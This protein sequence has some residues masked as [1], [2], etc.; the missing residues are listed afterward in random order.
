M[1]TLRGLL[2]LSLLTS[3]CVDDPTLGSGDQDVVATATTARPEVGRVQR[4]SGTACMGTLV[5]PQIVATNAGCAIAHDATSDTPRAGARFEFRDAA[6]VTRTIN[7]DRA[8][9][10][11]RFSF[12]HLVTAI[13]ASQATPA[14]FSTLKPLEDGAMTAFAFDPSGIF[15]KQLFEYA[16]PAEV[17]WDNVDLGGP[18]F[19]G[20]PVGGDLA[21]ISDRHAWDSGIWGSSS[22]DVFRTE[23]AFDYWRQFEDK[24][25][26]WHGQDEVGFDRYGTDYANTSG[27]NAGSCRALC[28][29]DPQCK[30][31]TLGPTGICWRKKGRTQL[32]PSPGA[33]SG[34]P[35]SSLTGVDVAGTVISTLIAIPP[36]LC[37]AA[38]AADSRCRVWTWIATD[39]WFPT[40]TTCRLKSTR[41]AMTTSALF[42]SGFVD[43]DFEGVDRPGRDYAAAPATLPKDCAK[44]CVEDERC[45]AFTWDGISGLCWL[46]SDVPFAA[47]S[48]TTSSGVRRGVET[49]V[50]RPG[51]D[52]RS[53]VLGT[54]ESPFVDTN[55]INRCQAAC[56]RDTACKAWVVHERNNAETRC[57]LKS[58]VGQ[59]FAKQGTVSGLK[60][61]EFQ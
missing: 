54:D 23:L 12:A 18:H 35:R 13:P 16:F 5:A 10:W 17:R 26:A 40:N 44:R 52:L 53:F 58:A 2:L 49:D 37:E 8:I 41:G 48:S 28:E 31:F 57:Q 56:A 61:L 15:G 39:Q 59:R 55:R 20:A 11:Q 38:C 14:A 46:K 47:A 27:Q 33:V 42:T 36:D 9:A 60:G 7:I 34:L 43:R 1:R 30:A 51:G 24:L 3:A 6:G 32:R 50:D 45:A 19:H 25:H 4:T 29:S 21:G 22:P